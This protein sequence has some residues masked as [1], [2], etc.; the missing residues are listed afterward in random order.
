M[1]AQQM[2]V[3]N[4]ANN[5]ANVNTT[6]FKRD[7]A[8][9]E[10]TFYLNHKLPGA[11]DADGNL[12]PTGIHVGLGSRVTSVQSDFRQGTFDTTN[13]DLDI[14][15]EGNGFFQLREPGTGEIVYTRAGNFSINNNGD[16]VLSSAGTGRPMEP[17]QP[18]KPAMNVPKMLPMAPQA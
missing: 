7:R 15:I 12:T 8:N 17:A 1:I 5:L 13:N 10:D 3:D 14:A 2:N 11:E 9:F 6:A 18:P 16:I 4:I